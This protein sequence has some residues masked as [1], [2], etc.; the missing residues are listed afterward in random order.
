MCVGA[1]IKYNYFCLVPLQLCR[2]LPIQSLCLI[3]CL[4]H[5][6]DYALPVEQ[7]NTEFII[8]KQAGWTVLNL[9]TLY[10]V[11]QLSN[12]ICKHRFTYVLLIIGTFLISKDFLLNCTVE[13]KR[14]VLLH[15]C[16]VTVSW[17][18]QFNSAPLVFV[19]PVMLLST[20][21]VS[22]QSNVWCLCGTKYS[23]RQLWAFD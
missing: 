1:Q 9:I 12:C 5:S 11:I 7:R 16:F 3:L 14:V 2:D 19:S 21:N 20:T 10:H 4:R 17:A 6:C 22:H 15:S 18:D 8:S 13:K 23:Y